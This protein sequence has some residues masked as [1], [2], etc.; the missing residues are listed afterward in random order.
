MSIQDENKH[1]VRAYV[2]AFNA[3]DLNALAALFEP[4]AEIQGVLGAVQLQR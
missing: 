2:A 3:G 4:D 1:V